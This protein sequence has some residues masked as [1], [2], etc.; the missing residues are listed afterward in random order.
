M[1]AKDPKIKRVRALCH[2]RNNEPEHAIEHANLALKLY[3]MSSFNHLIIAIAEAT[4]GHSDN[5]RRAYEIAVEDWPEDLREPG[6]FRATA[7]AGVL[8]LDAADELLK[9]RTEAEKLLTPN[10]PQ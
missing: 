8:W 9:L 3:D 2:L 1:E 7:D 6:A 10:G 5:A 4:L